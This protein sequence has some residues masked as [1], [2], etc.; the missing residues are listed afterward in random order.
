MLARG[1]MSRSTD[2][3][4]NGQTRENTTSK[5]ERESNAQVQHEAGVLFGGLLFSERAHDASERERDGLDHGRKGV[6]EADK[7]QAHAVRAI[8]GAR[9]GVRGGHGGHG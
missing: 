2:G 4:R 7:E 3:L 9:P 8:G 6:E 5:N 1:G